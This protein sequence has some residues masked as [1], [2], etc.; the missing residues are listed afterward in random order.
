[1]K[2]SL[3]TATFNTLPGLRETC[4]QVQAQT[5]VE[6]E[7]VVVDG[8]SS[9]GT[10]EWLRKRVRARKKGPV[11]CSILSDEERGGQNATIH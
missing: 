8:G 3:I 2:L 6:T 9:D 7:H 1:M 4:Q 5:G 11:N 10:P